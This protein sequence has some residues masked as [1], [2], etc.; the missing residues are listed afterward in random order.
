M[1]AVKY[2][3][4]EPVKSMEVE[5]TKVKKEPGHEDEYIEG[6]ELAQLIARTHPQTKYIADDDALVKQVAGAAAQGDV[7]VFLGSHGWRG[8]IE[9]TVAALG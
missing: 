2:K 1:E 7:I 9:R 5:L 8:M 3:V 4:L 6:D